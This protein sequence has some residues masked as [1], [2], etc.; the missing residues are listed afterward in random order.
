MD[1]QEEL[2]KQG[3]WLFKYRSYLPLTI[4]LIGIILS[5]RTELYSGTFILEETPHEIYFERLPSFQINHR[6]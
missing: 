6:C 3:N 2:E 5:L 1:L 4:L